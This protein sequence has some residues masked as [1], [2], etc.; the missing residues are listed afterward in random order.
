MNIPPS[1]VALVALLCCGYVLQNFAIYKLRQ[2]IDKQIAIS[3][4]QA[5]ASQMLID[6]MAKALQMGD[7]K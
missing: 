1:L 6:A 2:S 7:C 4:K 3:E 5:E